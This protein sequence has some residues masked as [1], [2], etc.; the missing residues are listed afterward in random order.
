MSR[1]DPYSAPMRE[2]QKAILNGLLGIIYDNYDTTRR[3]QHTVDSIYR[4]V[5][6]L[7]VVVLGLVGALVVFLCIAHCRRVRNERQSPLH[8]HNRKPSPIEI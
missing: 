6:F 1:L 5:V 7:L 4:V 3:V 2:E 8:Q